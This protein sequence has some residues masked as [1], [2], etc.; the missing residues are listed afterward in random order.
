MGS[1][2]LLFGLVRRKQRL[3]DLARLGIG[4]H[5]K[6][7]VLELLHGRI[8]QHLGIAFAL[9]LEVLSDRRLAASGRRWVEEELFGFGFGR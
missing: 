6:L 8:A 1:G 5:A 4:G 2:L 9:Q 3:V 7:G